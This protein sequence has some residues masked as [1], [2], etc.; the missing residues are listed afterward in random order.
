[1]RSVSGLTATAE[2][3]TKLTNSQYAYSFRYSRLSLRSSR[4]RMYSCLGTRRFSNNIVVMAQHWGSWKREK[5]RTRTARSPCGFSC[6]VLLWP[7]SVWASIHASLGVRLKDCSESILKLQAAAQAW[8]DLVRW[9]LRVECKTLIL[10][11][12]SER[13]KT[14]SENAR[15]KGKSHLHL[16]VS[17]VLI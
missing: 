4:S 17:I 16:A 10:F 12:F 3:E 14:K 5:A 15:P 9:G 2:D 11:F 13:V 1:M 6:G 8:R 7:Y